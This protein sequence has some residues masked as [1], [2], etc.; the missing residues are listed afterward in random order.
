MKKSQLRELV[1]EI[2]KSG[3]SEYYPGGETPGLT[4]DVFNTIL[5]NVALGKKYSDKEDSEEERIRRGNAL[6]DMGDI[7]NGINTLTNKSDKKNVDRILRGEDPIYEE[8]S[9][10]V[11]I[12]LNDLTADK[13]KEI[14][15]KFGERYGGIHFPNPSDSLT[16]VYDERSLEQWKDGTR[17]EY[18]NVEVMFYPQ[19]DVWF[20]KVKINDP[21]FTADKEVYTKR[22]AGWLDG[23]RGA[24][25]TS[26]LD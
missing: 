8:A 25:R 21:Q 15:P 23:E 17:E 5:K 1:L 18:G 20:N 10:G 26:G 7:E 24:G 2:L 14:F 12:M 13:I 16:S 22:K 11:G 3:R 19:E 9:N 4:P 6:M